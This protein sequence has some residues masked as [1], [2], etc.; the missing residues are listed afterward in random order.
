MAK[1]GGKTPSRI[2]LSD[3]TLTLGGQ[4][5]GVA[6]L[7]EVLTG[8]VD[9]SFVVIRWTNAWASAPRTS[10]SPMWETSNT[11]ALFRTAL[12]S[13]RIPVYWIGMS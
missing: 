8:D 9:V 6:A 10:N 7:E 4:S 3:L 2:E 11:P 1:L 5:T 13:S 12:C